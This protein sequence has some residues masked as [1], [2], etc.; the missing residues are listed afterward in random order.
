MPDKLVSVIVRTCGRPSILKETLK[1]I[2]AQTYPYVQVVVV[3]DGKE[4]SR[5]LIETQFSKMNI[6]YIAT[7]KKIGRAATGNI[8]LSIA[9]GV[10]LNFLDDDDLFYPQHLEKLVEFI[11]KKHA[12]AVYAIAEESQ[13]KVISTDPYKFKEKRKLIRYRQ[14][15][16]KLLLCGFNYIPIQSILFEKELYEQK[17]GFDESLDFLEDWDLWIR[18]STICDFDFLPEVTSRYFVPYKGKK[19][20]LRSREL[21]DAITPLKRKLYDYKI[22]LNVGEVKEEIDYVLNV[23]N[24]K[25]M[26]YYLKMIRNFILYRDF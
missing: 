15:Y 3:E 7:G 1:S 18:Y 14:P 12:K 4:I 11:N 24:Q 9:D 22:D 5:S 23:Y 16:N 25:S 20:L 13:I 26:V 19:K 21:E 2:E 10:Y 6:K 8:G 17:G